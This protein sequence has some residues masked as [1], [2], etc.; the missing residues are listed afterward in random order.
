[1]RGGHDID[2]QTD[3]DGDDDSLLSNSRFCVLDLTQEELDRI[4]TVTYQAEVSQDQER[5]TN[6]AILICASGHVAMDRVMHD[7]TKEEKCM[8]LKIKTPPQPFEASLCS[9]C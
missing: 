7:I 9:C 1:M 2:N 3:V 6:N 5:K 4:Q 8:P